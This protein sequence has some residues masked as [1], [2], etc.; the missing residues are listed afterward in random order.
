MKQS[1]QNPA[2]ASKR[3]LAD[4]DEPR[5]SH[6]TEPPSTARPEIEP[7]KLAAR[8]DAEAEQGRMTEPP[9]ATYEMLR[10]S[11]KMVAAHVVPLDEEQILRPSSGTQKVPKK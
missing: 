6:M 1:G 5:E 10:D 9:A 2:G 8:L 3:P 11:C 4:L 7:E